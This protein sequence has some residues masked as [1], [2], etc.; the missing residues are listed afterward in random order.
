MLMQIYSIYDSV[1][2]A[3]MRPFFA[4]NSPTAIREVVRALSDPSCDMARCAK[5]CVLY[6]VGSYDDATGAVVPLTP[7]ANLGILS[8]WAPAPV[9]EPRMYSPSSTMNE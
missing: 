4:V 3:F 7:V 1:V 9:K 6:H 5:D 8:E 2:G